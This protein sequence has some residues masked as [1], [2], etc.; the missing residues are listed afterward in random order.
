ML[1]LLQGSAAT[2]DV[3]V[4]PSAVGHTRCCPTTVLVTEQEVAFSTAAAISVP[5]ATTR[6]RW[7]GPTLTAAIGRILTL[8]E[9][10]LRYPRR[11]PS[12]F[13]TARMSRAMEHL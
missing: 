7:P 9:P 1:H 11:D 8:P 2:A 3:G 4:A 12:Y 5:P 13:E 10:R 6:R